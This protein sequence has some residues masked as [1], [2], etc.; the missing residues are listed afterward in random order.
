MK[1]LSILIVS[2]VLTRT[3][4]LR[5]DEPAAAETVVSQNSE[6]CYDVGHFVYANGGIGHIVSHVDADYVSGEPRLGGVVTVGYDWISSK[7]IGVGFL[8]NGYYTR[9]KDYMWDGGFKGYLIEHWSIN[10]FAPQ[11]V[12]RTRLKSSRWALRFAVGLGM[13]MTKETANAKGELIGRNYDYGYGTNIT[14]GAE[15][16]IA[17]KFAITGGLNVFQ[18]YVKQSYSGEKNDGSLVR[19]DLSLGAAYHF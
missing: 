12:G 14:F 17:K 6:Y 3:F 18:A 5:A 4:S 13:V 16:W 8:Y 1:R 9:F 7:K 2:A 15:Y 19:I 10:Y 11:F